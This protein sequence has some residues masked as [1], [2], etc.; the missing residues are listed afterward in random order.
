V[1]G[2]PTPGRDLAGTHWWAQPLAP[3]A[4]VGA[5]PPAAASPPDGRV[6]TSAGWVWD[7]PLGR[8]PAGGRARSGLGLLL[9]AVLGTAA[10]TGV[11]VHTVD[12]RAD[13]TAVTVVPAAGA[14]ASEGSRAS[15]HAALAAIA[16]S[17]VL[18]TD[19]LA[20]VGASGGAAGPGPFA[21][22]GAGTGIVVDAT[23]RVLTNAHVVAH[24]TAI[25]VTI[26]GRGTHTAAV[27]G[28]D[29]A[30]DLA[31][32]QVAGVSGL[33]PA[34]FA[35]SATVRVGDPVLAV[36]NAEG[37]GGSPSVTAGI[38]SATDRSL[39]DPTTALSGLLQTDA[40][41][42]PGNSGGPL[43]DA[44]GHVVGITTAVDRGSAGTSV[45]GIGYAIPANT[46]LAALPRLERGYAGST[47]PAGG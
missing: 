4:G 38:I 12:V 25:T 6:S 14:G 8:P 20:P 13:R 11:V 5:G 10:V 37:L 18:I 7:P 27:V 32:L 23:G 21:A 41:L 26:P 22:T 46:V 36:G 19:T 15:A 3:P 43:V 35:D 24:A 39:T 34:T 45:D 29:A 28:I 1:S 31:V 30:G 47:S 16:P 9:T 17:V 42:N 44:A 33:T 2:E 40:A